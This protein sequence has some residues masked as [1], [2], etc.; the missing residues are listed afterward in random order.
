MVFGSCVVLERVAVLKYAFSLFY[1]ILTRQL[2]LQNRENMGISS[3][4]RLYAL[5]EERSLS[6]KL[7][8]D[9]TSRWIKL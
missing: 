4:K 6:F 1:Y 9:S 2:Q 5:R 8:S 7:S 3:S